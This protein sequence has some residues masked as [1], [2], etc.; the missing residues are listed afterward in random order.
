MLLHACSCLT[1]QT[2]MNHFTVGLATLLLFAVAVCVQ[3]LPNG[4][5]AAAC[6]AIA[7]QHGGSSLPIGNSPF[8]LDI[9]A[10]DDG[11]GQF[12]YNPGVTYPSKMHCM[13][14]LNNE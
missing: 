5:P 1:L 10:F 2:R 8:M 7:P 9:S 14:S 4:A 12:I 6:A 11:A 3:S 13:L